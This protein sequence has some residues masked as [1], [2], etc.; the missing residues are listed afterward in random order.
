VYHAFLL[1][2]QPQQEVL[3]TEQVALASAHGTLRDV[4]SFPRVLR[5]FVEFHLSSP[6]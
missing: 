5:K 4:Y 6:S 1:C 3:G 2:Q